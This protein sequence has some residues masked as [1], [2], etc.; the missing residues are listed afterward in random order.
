MI[1]KVFPG[2]TALRC[3]DIATRL[4]RLKRYQTGRLEPTR[5]YMDAS[6]PI[7][8]RKFAVRKRIEEFH[9]PAAPTTALPEVREMVWMWR[10]DNRQIDLGA[11][12]GFDEL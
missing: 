5:K 6:R 7:K 2:V 4:G 10:P 9:P 8:G 3:D 1:A 11:T 12:H